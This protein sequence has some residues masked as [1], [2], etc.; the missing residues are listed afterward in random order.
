MGPDPADPVR[1]AL[2][3]PRDDI[4]LEQADDDGAFSCAQG[5]FR[6]YRRTLRDLGHSV[7]EVT[8]QRLAIPW[9]AWLFVLP[10]R[11]ALKRPPADRQGGLRAWWAPPDRLDARAATVLGLLGAASIIFGYVNT[12]FTQTITFAADEF[13]SSDTAQGAAGAI[14]R[15]GI[16]FAIGLVFLADRKG[17]RRMLVTSAVLAPLLCVSRSPFAVCV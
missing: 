10:V 3:T 17:R 6:T 15:C 2:R 12:L 14:V 16:I 4:L 9:F 1:V 5:P 7:E 13:G 8:E 11:A